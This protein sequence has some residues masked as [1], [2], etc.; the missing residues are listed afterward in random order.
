[1]FAYDQVAK[2]TITSQLWTCAQLS[3]RSMTCYLSKAG[4]Q[5]SRV[6]MVT[7]V[8]QSVVAWVVVNTLCP[9]KVVALHRVQ[10]TGRWPSANE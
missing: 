3:P 10:C 1:M 9:I 2:V 5:R 4:N 8:S 7:V 6:T